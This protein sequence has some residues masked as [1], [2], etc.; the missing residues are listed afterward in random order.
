MNIECNSISLI[1]KNLE[2][3]LPT[4]EFFLIDLFNGW[5]CYY[6]T[7]LPAKVCLILR[8][9]KFRLLQRLDSITVLDRLQPSESS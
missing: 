6:F 5:V 8:F 1:E 4:E 3:G 2:N 7:K 9:G